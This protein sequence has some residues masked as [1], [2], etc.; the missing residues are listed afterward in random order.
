MFVLEYNHVR[1]RGAT[2][3]ID[4]EIKLH[5]GGETVDMLFGNNPANPGDGRGATI[6]IENATGT[7]ALEFSFSEA[8]LGPNVAY[9]FEVVPVAT[10]TAP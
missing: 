10:S 2:A 1:V 8:L 5:E 3:P 4:F 9:R 7:D 6:G